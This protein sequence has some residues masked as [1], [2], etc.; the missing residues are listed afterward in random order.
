MVQRHNHVAEKMRDIVEWLDWQ[1][2]S[3]SFGLRSVEDAVKLYDYWQKH[4]FLPEM[5]DGEFHYDCHGD[6]LV[7]L[8]QHR[9]A[10]LGYDPLA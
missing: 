8:A 10:A 5:A 2:E 9:I 1:D 4:S 7:P 3:L 6:P